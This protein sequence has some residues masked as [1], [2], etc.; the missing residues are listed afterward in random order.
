MNKATGTLAPH[1]HKYKN[2]AAIHGSWGI[3]INNIVK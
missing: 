3:S 1:A 2:A